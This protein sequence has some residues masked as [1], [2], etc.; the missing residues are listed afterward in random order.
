MAEDYDAD[1]IVIGLDIKGYSL[2][3]L[4][5]QKAAQEVLD[6][7]LQAA[8][9]DPRLHGQTVIWIDGGDGGYVLLEGS[10]Q[11]ALSALQKFYEKLMWENKNGR[12]DDPVFV[13]AALHTDKL[14]RWASSQF[15]ARYTG[16]AINDCSRLLNGMNKNQSGQVVCSGEFLRKL[17]SLKV[18]VMHERL[19]DIIDKHGRV[20]TAFNIYRSPGFGVIAAK[21]DRHPDPI[22]WLSK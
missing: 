1:H 22:E 13:R 15:G 2:R 5:R 21:E 17:N 6:R 20:H 4:S 14:I 19:R 7:C 12:Q 11:N 18:D 9:P 16:N 8:F 10:S 3:D